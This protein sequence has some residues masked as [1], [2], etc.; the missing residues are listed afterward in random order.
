MSDDDS[1]TQARYLLLNPRYRD[2][3]KLQ[4]A[5]DVD[6]AQGMYAIKQPHLQQPAHWALRLIDLQRRA[7]V[8]TQMRQ[9]VAD[10]TLPRDLFCGWLITDAEPHA[11]KMHIETH[12]V[13]RTPDGRRM[14]LRYFDPRVLD[15]L[16]YI[17]DDVQRRALMGPIAQWCF[18]DA[19]RRIQHIERPAPARGAIA[20][21]SE[22]WDAIAS[23]EEVERLRNG[24]LEVLD[25][26]PLPANAYRQITTWMVI[27][28]EY[29]L[30]DMTDRASFVLL[31]IGK[32]W[33]FDRTPMFRD[34]LERHR[35]T[36][37]PL[38]DF[39]KNMTPAD[40]KRIDQWS[41]QEPVIYA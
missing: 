11:L 41:R 22:Q 38:T 9:W 18:L 39:F 25:G 4:K 7:D 19:N 36:T 23:T 17:L 3:M 10:S 32:G 6:A 15:Q 16:V 28:D 37:A 13:H 33:R 35:A 30:D 5:D 24:W 8:R 26:K 14:L 34:L 1:L 40:W 31:G 2:L 20:I 29:Q 27:A 12:M 21:R